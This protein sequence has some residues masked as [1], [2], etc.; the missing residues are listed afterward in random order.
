MSLTR[1]RLLLMILAASGAAFCQQQSGEQHRSLP[2]PELRQ[3]LLMK[4]SATGDIRTVADLLSTRFDYYD[5]RLPFSAPPR[6]GSFVYNGNAEMLESIHQEI[7]Y[8]AVLRVLRD[9]DFV[10]APGTTCINVLRIAGAPR[11]VPQLQFQCVND[12]DLYQFHGIFYL[13]Y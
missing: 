13:E 1:G 9:G 12:G 3:E 5:P 7:D 10:H 4:L 6:S 2:L 8:A 11:T